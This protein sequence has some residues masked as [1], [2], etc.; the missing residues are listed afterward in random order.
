MDLEV[1]YSIYL[2][3]GYEDSDQRYSV[4]YWLHGRGG[5]ERGIQPVATLHAAVEAGRVEPMVLVIANGGIASGYI[6]NPTT[7]VMGES[8]IL[9]ELIPHV[10]ATYR[11]GTNQRGR[12]LGGMSMGGA[13]TV[14]T[15]L[16]H[17]ELFGAVVA[18]AGALFDYE[19]VMERHWVTDAALARTYD[20]Y[21]L[22]RQQAK[23]LRET[24]NVKLVIGTNDE[25][26]SEN[27]RFRSHLQELGIPYEYDELEGVTHNLAQYLG[28]LGPE[29]FEFFSGHLS[30]SGS[31]N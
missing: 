21:L 23:S 5:S 28:E 12:G 29:L 20:P 4:V 19:S 9:R 8:V 6:D 30:V 1:G 26:L 3:P 27:R 10:E 16:R 11:V 18:V 7:G 14:R 22:S 17:P 2:P 25:W 15:A 31:I 13:G 24:F